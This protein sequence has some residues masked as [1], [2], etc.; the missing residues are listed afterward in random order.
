MS[1]DTASSGNESTHANVVK[2][3]LGAKQLQK[4]RREIRHKKEEEER[5]KRQEGIGTRKRRK[6]ERRRRKKKEVE[7]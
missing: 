6:E 7:W 5:C 3:Y 2:Y 4:D 1:L